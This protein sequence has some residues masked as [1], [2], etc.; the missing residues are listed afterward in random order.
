MMV[1]LL[2]CLLIMLVLQLLTP[3]WW[4]IMAVPLLYGLIK[5]ESGA[6]AFLVGMASSGL[7]WLGASYYFWKSGG[8]LIANRMAAVLGIAQA[9]YLVAATVAL[10]LLSGGFAAGAGFYLKALFRKDDE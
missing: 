9:G 6:R 2:L 3:H 10:A 5:A 7:L 4:W 8:E 1:D